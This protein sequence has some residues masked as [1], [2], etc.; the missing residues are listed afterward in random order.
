MKRGKNKGRIDW[1]KVE[2][3]GNFTLN[4]QVSSL[5]LLVLSTPFREELFKK[6]KSFCSQ[7][8]AAVEIRFEKQKLRALFSFLLWSSDTRLMIHRCWKTKDQTIKDSSNGNSP[9]SVSFEL[10]KS[11]LPSD[12]TFYALVYQ[13]SSLYFLAWN[14]YMV[15]CEC[16]KGAE[17]LNLNFLAPCFEI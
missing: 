8:M 1:I 16:W 9:F 5:E 15:K 12:R 3:I 17:D 6:F 13:R 7:K 11:L 4:V 10:A 2:I 14:R